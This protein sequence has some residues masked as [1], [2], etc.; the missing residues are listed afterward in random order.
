MMQGTLP[1]LIV[2]FSLIVKVAQHRELL[3]QQSNRHVGRIKPRT[4]PHVHAAAASVR[5]CFFFRAH[6][7][8]LR[9]VRMLNC[10]PLSLA[11]AVPGQNRATSKTSDALRI[12]FAL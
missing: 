7:Y 10:Q 2:A 4:P 1:F 6:T 3:F 5:I 11:V 12:L 8:L 9:A